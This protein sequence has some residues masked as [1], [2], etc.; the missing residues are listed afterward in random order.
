LPTL[1]NKAALILLTGYQTPEA[2]RRAGAARL[3]AWLQ[4]RKARNADAVAAAAVEAAHA[5]HTVL[6][7]Q[8]LASAMVARLAQEVIALDTEIAATATPKSS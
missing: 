8:D 7:G 5:Q 6:P 4:K 2:L 3:V 1:N